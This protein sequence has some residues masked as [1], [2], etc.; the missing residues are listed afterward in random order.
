MDAAEQKRLQNYLEVC[1]G[2]ENEKPFEPTVVSHIMNCAITKGLSADCIINLD[3]NSAKFELNVAKIMVM[4]GWPKDGAENL[5]YCMN[6]E[7]RCKGVS[8]TSLGNQMLSLA[9]AGA[10]NGDAEMMRTSRRGCK[11]L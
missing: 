4:C 6:I 7:G 9:K 8:R 11:L 1:P 2:G 5:M 3:P 10:N